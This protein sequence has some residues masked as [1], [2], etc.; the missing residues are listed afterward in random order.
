MFQAK[1]EKSVKKKEDSGNLPG[2][3]P[4]QKIPAY[5]SIPL[6]GLNE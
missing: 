6:K 3:S 4:D 2:D 5:K 1:N